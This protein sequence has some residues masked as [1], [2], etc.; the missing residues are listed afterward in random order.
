MLRE[1]GTVFLLLWSV[2]QFDRLTGFSQRQIFSVTS[3][4][5]VLVTTEQWRHWRKGVIITT[6]EY[7]LSMRRWGTRCTRKKTGTFLKIPVRHPGVER[8]A[9][10]HSEVPLV[11]ERRRARRMPL[12]APRCGLWAENCTSWPS[13]SLQLRVWCIYYSL[14]HSFGARCSPRSEL[15]LCLSNQDYMTLF[16][17]K[18]DF[19]LIW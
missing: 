1:E 11:L 18:V 10:C 14:L 2:E 3:S 19:F 17:N 6:S 12:E 7:A 13:L 5:A 9:C 16:H 4:S 8:A 15:Q